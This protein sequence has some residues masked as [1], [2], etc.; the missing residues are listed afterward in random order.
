HE[1]EKTK[2]IVQGLPKIEQI[3][4]AKKTTN[5]EKINKNPHEKLNNIFSKLKTK[6]DNKTST[7]I[8]IQKVQQSLVKKIQ[9][10][11]KSQGIKIANK[12][13]EVIVKQM[14]NRV[15]IKEK[16]EIEVLPGEIIEL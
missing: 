11:Y 4:E 2:D 9:D 6:F 13:I 15:V 14:T 1:S 3:L 10:V 12:H 16:G 7:R 8:A 5:L